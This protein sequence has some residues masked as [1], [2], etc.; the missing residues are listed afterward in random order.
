[1]VHIRWI[2][3]AKLPPGARVTLKSGRALSVQLTANRVGA[4]RTARIGSIKFRGGTTFSIKVAR[5]GFVGYYADLRVS[6]TKKPF[7]IREQCIPPFGSSPVR[8]ATI[9]R[10]R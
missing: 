6:T 8:C 9:N 2:S 7:P 4:V 5:T 3:L 1:L 10:G